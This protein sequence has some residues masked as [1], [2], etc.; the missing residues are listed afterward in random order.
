[1]CPAGAGGVL[2]ADKPGEAARSIKTLFATVGDVAG[3][4]DN[5]PM[6]GGGCSAKALVKFQDAVEML[7]SA[8]PERDVWLVTQSFGGRLAV[9]TTIGGIENR[10]ATGKVKPWPEKRPVRCRLSAPSATHDSLPPPPP[11]PLPR[12]RPSSTAQHLPPCC[13]SF[14]RL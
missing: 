5:P 14:R 2:P 10:D 6:G 1:M 8:N 7:C 12:P 11:S 9:H 13:R 3:P 4:M